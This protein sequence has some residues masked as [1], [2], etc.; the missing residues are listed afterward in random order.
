[1]CGI[2]FSFKVSFFVLLF[3]PSY[4][5]YCFV[6]FFN[7]IFNIQKHYQPFCSL[8]CYLYRFTVTGEEWRV[9]Y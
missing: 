3:Y 7:L 5:Y 2:P 4:L 9:A 6:F 8:L 1:M